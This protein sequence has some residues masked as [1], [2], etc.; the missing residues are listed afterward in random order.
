VDKDFAD[1]YQAA[2]ITP[3]PERLEQRWRGIEVLSRDV[4]NT[5]ILEF[6]RL[7]YGLPARDPSTTSRFRDAFKSTDAAFLMQG[8]DLE[9]TILAG[10]VIV[11]VLSSPEQHLGDVAALAAL[12]GQFEGKRGGERPGFAVARA[13]RHLFRRSADLR[14]GAADV[15]V[16]VP[17]TFAT[18]AAK[19][20]EGAAAPDPTTTA[21]GLRTLADAIGSLARSTGSAIKQLQTNG[22]LQREESNILWWIFGGY[23]RDLDRP[24]SEFHRGTACLIAGKELSD[25]IEVPPGPAAAIAMLDRMILGSAVNERNSTVTLVEALEGA[26]HEWLKS[27]AH[28]NELIGQH[29]DLW[30]TLLGAQRFIEAPNSMAW[31][32]GVEGVTK[33][34]V[35]SS[36]SILSLASQVYN[37]HR[38]LRALKG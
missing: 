38:L 18:L 20:A 37:E 30:P 23:S 5:T 33:V 35:R 7:F 27:W 16:E 15:A 8:N 3:T 4:S 9:V 2:G 14:S 6:V 25:V 1:W 19:P 29:G 31:I 13:R 34:S 26:P 11:T 32:T 28:G 10:A 24:L 17:R 22:R 36:L 12:C 21:Q